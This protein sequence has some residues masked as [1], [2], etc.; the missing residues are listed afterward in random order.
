MIDRAMG[1]ERLRRRPPA[2]KASRSIKAAEC[3]VAWIRDGAI[4]HELCEA[5]RLTQAEASVVGA[6]I[7]EF[8]PEAVV[9]DATAAVCAKLMKE[10]LARMIENGSPRSE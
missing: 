6:D 9:P 3:L 10:I 4:V 1:F 8:D 2:A 5:I 7:V